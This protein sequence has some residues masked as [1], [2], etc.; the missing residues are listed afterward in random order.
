MYGSFSRGRSQ[1]IIAWML[2]RTCRIV[3]SPGSLKVHS[4]TVSHTASVLM[5]AYHFGPSQV[6]RSERQTNYGLETVPEGE[7]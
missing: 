4:V 2:M 5:F 3:D 1:K 6:P 7:R